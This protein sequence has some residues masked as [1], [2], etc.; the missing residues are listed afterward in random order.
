VSSTLPL[1]LAG[2]DV[3]LLAERAL[4]WPSARALIIADV[5][6]GKAAAFRAATVPIPRGT[7]AADLARLDGA[8][9]RTG[10]TRLVI[11]GD[12]VHAREGV[13]AE[14][15]RTLA[16]WRATQPTLEI[17][18]VRGN[19]DLAAGDPPAE[20]RIACVDAP[21]PLGPFELHHHPATGVDGYA[22]AGH[23]HPVAVLAG[24][25]RQRLRLPCFHFGARGGVLPAFGSFTGGAV[26]EPTPGDRVA[27][28]A[29][30]AVLEVPVTVSR[31]RTALPED[32]GRSRA[33]RPEGISRSP[34]VRGVPPA[35]EPGG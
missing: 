4:F 25:G 18:L 8:L 17:T 22:L 5:H 6:W 14:T 34:A 20:L 11:L 26:V 1:R 27:V 28:I 35:G 12:L 32:V 33:A 3:A 10:A 21:H 7:T 29:E 30:S 2:T 13:T 31:A 15:V 19:H 16:A 23:L 9:A 24:A